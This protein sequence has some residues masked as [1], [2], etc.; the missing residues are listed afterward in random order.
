MIKPILKAI[1]G[2][3]ALANH[4]KKFGS[5]KDS[6][7]AKPYIKE[8]PYN[9]RAEANKPNKIY[10]MPDSALLLSFIDKAT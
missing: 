10:F 2:I 3:G 4:A 9:K 6:V 1:I 8:I 5:C 7:P